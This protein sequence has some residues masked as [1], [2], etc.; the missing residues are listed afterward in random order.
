LRIECATARRHRIVD[1]LTEAFAALIAADPFAFY[2]GSAC[3]FYA[4]VA[5]LDDP[6]ADERTRRVWIQGDLQAEDFGTHL[7][8]QGV[9]VFDVNDFDEAYLGHFTWDLQRFAASMALLGWGKTLPDADIDGLVE[10]YLRAY[11]DQVRR[12]STLTTTA[13]SRCTWGPRT[14]QWS[15]SCRPP[16]CGPGWSCS[17]RSSK[18]KATT[19]FPKR[20][21]RA[22][23]R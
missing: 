1:T 20:C 11:L 23:A 7:N 18:P 17:T 6:G 10:T 22:P 8:A 5:E 12:S 3:L 21:G 2:R 19:G 4:D 9:L 14:A 15:S 13:T 16:G